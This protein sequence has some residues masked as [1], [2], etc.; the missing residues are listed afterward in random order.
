VKEAWTVTIESPEDEHGK[1]MRR[2]VAISDLFV[3]NAIM[4]PDAPKLSKD[5][6]DQITALR[7]AECEVWGDE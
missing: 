1:Y 4:R 7:L 2:I 6:A 5:G 3:Q